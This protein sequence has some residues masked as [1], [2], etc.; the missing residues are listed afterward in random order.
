MNLHR[1]IKIGQIETSG[2]LFVAPLAGYT[3]A[4]FR[5]VCLRNGADM[6]FTEM[7]SC[8]GLW[9]GSDRTADLM[10]RA[11]SESL[12]AIQ[13]F[14]GNLQAVERAIPH[15][16]RME[17]AILDFNC[18]CPV[19]K[20]HRSHAGS[21][22]LKT[23]QIFFDLLKALRN[24]TPQNVAITVKIR[25]GWDMQQI[26]YLQLAEKAFLAG[27]D[28]L[29]LHPRTRSQGYTGTADWSHLTQLK[30][31][32]PEKIICGSGDLFSP[33][34]AKNMLEETGIDAIMFAR[35]LIGNPF[36]FRQTKE[37]FHRGVY[38]PISDKEKIQAA[39]THLQQVFA[40][41]RSI[42]S[43]REFKKHL[44]AYAKG[45]HD[46]KPLKEAFSQLE[47]PNQAETLLQSVLDRLS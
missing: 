24:N 1:A 20:V 12:L 39:Y 13:L 22:L 31:N 43:L 19:P 7:V 41:D 23:P 36:I 27:V 25:S 32:F 42:K 26:N 9:R 46:G 14:A 2:N 34:S 3:D 40:Q 29:T 37:Y 10:Q 15:A 33:E 47:E 21:A 17:P 44:L 45:I 35:G 38:T 16:L 5:E 18:G 28:M 6:A 11:P 30:R 8:E 4:A